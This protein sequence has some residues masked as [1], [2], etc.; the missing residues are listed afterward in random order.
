M[1][2]SNTSFFRETRRFVCHQLPYWSVQPVE[3]SANPRLGL[4]TLIDDLQHRLKFFQRNLVVSSSRK[5]V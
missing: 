4:V 3:S 5:K 2:R 1:G